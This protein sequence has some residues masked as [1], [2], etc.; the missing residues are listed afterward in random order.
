M[1]SE[2]EIV[3][4]FLYKRSGKTQLSFSE[5]YLTLSMD[6]NWFT[7]EDA[8]SFVNN[9]LKQK[10]LIKRGDT[11]QPNFDYEKI[12]VPVGFNPSKK[13]FEGKENIKN[14]ESEVNILDKIIKRIFEKT[15]IDKIQIKNKINS[16][17]NE[18]NITKDV[19]ALLIGK[20]HNINLDDFF[21][22]IEEV[23]IKESKEL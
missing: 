21:I 14:E 13:V 1:P 6:L 5:I 15:N 8:K 2:S 17:A 11:L 3:I 18:K 10:Y 12:I 4:S 23:I 9:A 16:I 22:E 19:A 7:P 20:E